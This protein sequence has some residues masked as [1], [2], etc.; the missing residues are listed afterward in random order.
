MRLPHTDPL[1][2]AVTEAIRAGDL[3]TLEDL[4]RKHAGLAGATIER[5]S[6]DGTTERRSLLHVVT[7]WPGHF[8]NGPQ[9]VGLLVA[10]RAD[11]N[12]RF[13]GRHRE[14][15]LH[16]A[17]SSNDVAVLDALLDAGADLEADGGVIAGGTPLADAVAFAQWQAA[18]RLVERGAA[19]TLW[20][21]AALGLMD[22]VAS[23]FRRGHGSAPPHADV[24]N[25][26]WCAC[27][28]GQLEAAMYLLDRGADRN[29]IGHDGLT[30][31]DA[32]RRA[33]ADEVVRWLVAQ[34]GIS[35]ATRP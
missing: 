16:W 13:G 10:H 12:A 34:G 24:T 32:A 7:D 30:P 14:T 22:R 23:Y 27:H 19:T 18:R 17:A 20:Q 3:A 21:A 4:V 15:P 28:G 26:F 6:G 5:T 33:G 2:A 11:V 35:A 29:W 25:A 9:T 8:S 1:A 31:L